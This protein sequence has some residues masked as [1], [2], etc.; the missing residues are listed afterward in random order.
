MNSNFA[1]STIRVNGQSLLSGDHQTSA[2]ASIANLPIDRVL[3][4]AGRRDLPVKGTLT[5]NA[6]LSGTLQNPRGNGTVTIANGSAYNE[7]FT[8]VQA[9]VNL[10]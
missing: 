10:H 9:S 7:P 2:T 4:V 5:A 1:G 8:R 6:Q 3:A